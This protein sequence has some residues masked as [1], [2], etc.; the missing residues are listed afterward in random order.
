LIV[1]KS[2]AKL[3]TTTRKDSSSKE[4]RIV[5]RGYR[6][7]GF[8]DDDYFSRDSPYLIVVRRREL[9]T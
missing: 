2:P 5:I 9:M 8:Y 1:A 3:N 6:I 7:L 4:Q